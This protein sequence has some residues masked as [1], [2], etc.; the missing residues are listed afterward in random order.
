MRWL[1]EVK[2]S[3]TPTLAECLAHGHQS[4]KRPTEV[5]VG[6][7]CRQ[8]GGTAPVTQQEWDR[9]AKAAGLR[10][11]E[12]VK[13]ATVKAR[14]T[15]RKCDYSWT[16]FP[17]AVTRGQGCPNCAGVKRRSPQEWDAVAK[18]ANLT[19]VDRPRS[20]HSPTRARC[21]ACQHEWSPAPKR[22][23]AGGGCPRC[24]GQVVTQAEWDQ[25]AA[26]RGITWLEPITNS[27]TKT[28]ARHECGLEWHVVP[29]S[30]RSTGCPSCAQYG[31]KP[32]EP[33]LL[34]LLQG[35]TD[36]ALKIGVANVPPPGT[37]SSRLK[38]HQRNGWIV[39]RTWELPTGQDVYDVE[40]AVVRW[41]REDL[42]LPPARSRGDG[43]TETVSGD[44]MTI[45]RVV[46]YVN[47]LIKRHQAA[48]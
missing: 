34:Y 26:E 33:G 1:G 6:T 10:W 32:N 28:L 46:R 44:Q 3:H 11:T 21:G 22:I 31:F 43:F 37:Q 29:N 24:A 38:K 42:G 17:D 25:R 36:G 9:R 27:Q 39:Q 18:I 35:V 8:C 2:N 14:A 13:L 30:L 40:Q 7:G 5:R 12:P 45:R 48:V 4:L 16:V 23:V 20:G 19:W 41:W 15:C 47:K